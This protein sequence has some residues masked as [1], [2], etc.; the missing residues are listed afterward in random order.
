[1]SALQ[2][3]LPSIHPFHA[4]GSIDEEGLRAHFRRLADAGVNVLVA[5][6][7]SGESHTFSDD[8]MRQ[9]L[10]IAGEEL[11]GRVAVRGMGRMGRTADQVI[12]FVRQVEEAKLDGIHIYTV[13]I[14][15]GIVP[16]VAEQEH[17]LRTVLAEVDMPAFLS[18]NMVAGF[19]YPVDLVARIVADHPVIDGVIVH[20][21]DV[22]YLARIIDAIGDKVS[23]FVSPRNVLNGLHLGAHGVAAPEANVVP[24][25]TAAMLQAFE[26]GDT[27]GVSDAF[28]VINRIGRLVQDHGHGTTKACLDALG[29]PGGVPRPPRLPLDDA[30]RRHVAEVVA[31]LR[32]REREGLDG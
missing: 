28:G 2:A 31:E 19:D 15:H 32:I 16:S 14:G 12:E 21:N 22:L 23:V 5:N 29:L 26:T 4:D 20:R 6:E 13:E 24:R 3:W 11:R 30:A 9:V 17:Y 8:D 27:A 25:T 7:G 18:L 10:R 1:M